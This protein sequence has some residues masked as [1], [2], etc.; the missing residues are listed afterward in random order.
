[1]RKRTAGPGKVHQVDSD[2]MMRSTA[3][4]SGNVREDV[5]L[6][7]DDHLHSY[8]CRH[9]GLYIYCRHYAIFKQSLPLSSFRQLAVV[10]SLAACC[11]FAR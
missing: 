10:H 5:E 4:E 6:Y 7:Q 2:A 1:M 8:K 11:V 9:V 3:R